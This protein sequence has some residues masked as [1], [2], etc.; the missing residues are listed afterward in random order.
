VLISVSI[1]ATLPWLAI[2]GAIT[3]AAGGLL[4]VNG[5]TLA[6]EIPFLAA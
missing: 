4:M 3:G 6:V 2:V 5:Y 1:V